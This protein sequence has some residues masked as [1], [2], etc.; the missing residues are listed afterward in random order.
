MDRVFGALAGRV[1]RVDVSGLTVLN[2]TVGRD[3]LGHGR[4]VT[5]LVADTGAGGIPV[6]VLVLDF[7]DQGQQQVTGLREGL[8]QSSGVRVTAAK[9]SP[10]RGR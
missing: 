1:Q 7:A 4:P 9:L 6:H 8:L 2:V 3:S 5:P 10:K